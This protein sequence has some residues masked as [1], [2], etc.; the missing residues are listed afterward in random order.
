MSGEDLF[1]QMRKLF[2]V[3]TKTNWVLPEVT[4]FFRSVCS[5]Q[6]SEGFKFE[7]IRNGY[8]DDPL[9]TDNAWKEAKVWHIH[10][11]CRQYLKKR[12]ATDAK[13]DWRLLSDSLFSRMPLSHNHII[14]TIVDS[15]KADI[16]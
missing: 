11:E 4:Q 8:M 15:L 1:G 5:P 9:N 13:L 3:E 10:Y 16:I 6:D 2:K 12:F 7:L 14:K